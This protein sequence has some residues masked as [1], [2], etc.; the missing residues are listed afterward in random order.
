[1]SAELPQIVVHVP[2]E[3]SLNRVNSCF[4]QRLFF[5]AKQVPIITRCPTFKN[6]LLKATIVQVNLCSPCPKVT[7]PK[8]SLSK[9]ANYE[10]YEPETCSIRVR[11][12]L[13][14]EIKPEWISHLVCLL[15]WTLSVN[16]SN[17]LLL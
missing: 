2:C 3:M 15:N 17:L 5:I 12:R 1:M 13:V 10:D 7:Y 9:L 8:F 11:G 4:K 6:C 14:L 16:R